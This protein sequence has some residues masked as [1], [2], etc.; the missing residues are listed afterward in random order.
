ML[1]RAAAAATARFLCPSWLEKAL[2]VFFGRPRL[3]HPAS[4]PLERTGA[5]AL[6][7]QW[8][9]FA[10]F[11]ALCMN[12]QV[13]T[14]FLAAACPPLH[15]WTASLLAG[16]GDGGRRAGAEKENAVMAAV[17]AAQAA[18]A[19][20]EVAEAAAEEGSDGAVVGRACLRW[21]LGVYF[22]V[23]AVLH[24]NFLPWT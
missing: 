2:G 21:Y 4:S 6:V 11:A 19:A 23:G 13:A 5:A 14:R 17:P 16:G 12:V 9:F 20:E 7:A 24:A 15:W 3:P 18:G 1:R 8:A 22:V 10:V